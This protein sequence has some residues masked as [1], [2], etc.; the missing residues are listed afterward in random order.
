MDREYPAGTYY[1]SP[2]MGV[3]GMLRE[4]YTSGDEKSTVK[5]TFP[6]GYTIDQIV[7][8]LAINGVASKNALYE[9]INSES[10][11]EKYDFLKFIK[12]K[13]Q[14]Y[15]ALEGYLYPDTYQ[16]YVGENPESVINRFLSN[17]E[18]KW[19][20][21]FAKKAESSNYNIDQIITVA[22]ILQKE[23]ND[24]EQMGVIASIIYNRLESS[25]FPFINCDSTSKYISAHE[26]ELKEAGSYVNLMMHYDTYQVN[27]LPVGPIC[28]P[29]A[30]AIA[31]AISPDQTDFYYFLHDSEGRIY[32][33]RT[34]A[35]HQA[36][37]QYIG[38]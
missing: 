6:E 25:S 24:A 19:N 38:N 22:S 33:A 31:A 18:D 32:T 4:I 17:F 10:F 14:R 28:N 1:L 9:V 20:A 26:D 36:N 37:Q 34:V 30:D 5:I 16:F 13:A 7:D 29:G 11:Y 15:R 23:A 21:S 3:E 8:K 35:E 12:D 2:S 27:G